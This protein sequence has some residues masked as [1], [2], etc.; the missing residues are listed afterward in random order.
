M[1]RCG[2]NITLRPE[3]NSV[4]MP[5]DV[6]FCDRPAAGCQRRATLALRSNC[7]VAE[8]GTSR[9]CARH[10]TCSA[11]THSRRFRMRPV[12]VLSIFLAGCQAGAMADD[13]AA[14]GLPDAGDGSTGPLSAPGAPQVTLTNG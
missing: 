5:S 4:A 1:W 13:E 6:S 8:R 14:L 11:R 9:A 7:C 3:R 10:A 2:R 12:L